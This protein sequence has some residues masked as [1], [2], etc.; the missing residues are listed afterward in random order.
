LA[1]LL[2]FYKDHIILTSN[3]QFVELDSIAGFSQDL[4]DYFLC[5]RN[6]NKL[7]NF[8]HDLYT[9]VVPEEIFVH[10]SKHI[11]IFSVQSI[12]SFILH[13]ELVV[14]NNKIKLITMARQLAQWNFDH[15]YCGRCGLPTLNL[16]N[17][18]HVEHAKE[19]K[20]C[21][22]ISY[23]RVTPCILAAVMREDGK[24]K[25]LLLGR[26]P[27]FPAGV[28]S[29]LAG[30]VDVAE[31]AE[32]TVIREVYEE[33]RITI[34]NLQ[35][36][37]SQPWPFPHSLMLAYTADYVSGEIIIDRNELE[38]AQWFDFNNIKASHALILP[39]KGS[40]SRMLID[41]L[42]NI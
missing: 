17:P 34:A 35:Y 33:A 19:C 28:Y 36:F 31:T 39:A 3:N 8:T 32:E 26:S 40:L 24:S 18:H 4:A 27:H 1:K 14:D 38:D 20:V 21:G 13:S 10:F 29:L 41:Y 11:D 42:I 25:Q 23:P 5:L 37:G 12:R 9:V 15:Q 6:H 30:F 7:V 22:L 2:A 16:V